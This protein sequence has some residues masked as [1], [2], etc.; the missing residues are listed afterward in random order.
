MARKAITV[1]AA[2]NQISKSRISGVIDVGVVSARAGM[3][4]MRLNRLEPRTL[5]R[6]TSGWRRKLATT[7]VASSGSEVPMAIN[8]NPMTASDTPAARARST[9]PSTSSFEPTTR[10]PTPATTRSSEIGTEALVLMV[11]VVGWASAALFSL[12]SRR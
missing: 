10:S 3:I 11:S 6:A 8:V 1:T 7:A 5:P 9:A 12:R 2:M 4:A